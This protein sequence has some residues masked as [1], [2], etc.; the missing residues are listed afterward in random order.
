MK[1]KVRIPKISI[2]IYIIILLFPLVNI[3]GWILFVHT[4]PLWLLMMVALLLENRIRLL[5]KH[6]SC[7][8]LLLIIDIIFTYFLLD[9]FDN[10]LK[11]M[12]YHLFQLIVFI[13]LINSRFKFHEIKLLLKSYQISAIIIVIKQLIQHTSYMT[14]G[15]SVGRYT[16]YNFGHPVDLNFLGACLVAP[17]V[18][19]F[20]NCMFKGFSQKN[21]LYF[22]F[23]TI[24]I[25]LTGS[26][27]ALLGI[28]IA[29][30]Y[31]CLSNDFFSFRNIVM[32]IVSSFVVLFLAFFLPT[33]LT[34]RLTMQGLNDSSNEFRIRIWQAAYRVYESSPIYGRGIGS[35]FS[36]GPLYGGAPRMSQHNFLLEIMTDYGTIGL[37]LFISITIV[38]FIESVQARDNLMIA[39]LFSTLIVAFMIPGFTSAFLWIN[40]SL[41]FIHS[42]MYKNYRGELYDFNNHEYI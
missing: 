25:I 10:S 4:F 17:A 5:S 18:I 31:L 19:S 27:G 24:G 26:R 40:L 12:F 34:H 28:V 41:V 2:I 3:F 9:R 13:F 37:L 29:C 42:R 11:L 7:L 14:H 8:V 38:A 16:I 35:I 36:L 20:Y 15:V 30:L 33:S 39:I 6:T 1:L 32:G 23:P 22:F 21:S